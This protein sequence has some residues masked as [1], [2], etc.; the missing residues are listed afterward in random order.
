MKKGKVFTT[1]LSSMLVLSL[2]AGCGNSATNSQTPTP[3][4][5]QST[6]TET[7]TP[8]DE[9]PYADPIHFSG[10]GL[11]EL[12]EGV[13]Y[14]N[15]A[16]Y[17]TLSQKFNFTYEL[18]PMTWDNWGE[19]NRLWISSGD[20]PDL[21]FWDFNYTEYKNYAEQGLIRALPDGWEAKYPN[22]NAVV[23]A[24]GIKDKI[25]FDGKIYA[26]PKPV[27]MHFA[28]L[29]ESIS[30]TSVYYRADWVKELGLEP[31]GDTVTVDELASFINA[32]KTAD[33]DG[34]GSGKTIGITANYNNAVSMFVSQKNKGWNSFY[35]KDGK[36]VWGPAQPETLEGI[37]LLKKYY[38]MG[39]LDPDFYLNDAKENRNK[40]ASGISA[41]TYDDGTIDNLNNRIK[42]F[43]AANPDK[44]AAS[45]IGLT[46]LVGE[47]GKWHGLGGANFWCASVFSPT[48]SEEKMDRILS[49]Y[50]Y[51][52]SK[53]GQELVGLGIEGTDWERTADGYKLLRSANADGTIP[54]LKTV[55]PSAAF[56]YLLVILPD[57]FSFADPTADPAV[58]DQVVNMYNVKKDNGDIQPYDY[59]FQFYSS[60]AKSN[61][62]VAT[63]D[64]IVRIVM[65]PNAD[66]DAEWA[67]F[68]DAQKGM[69]N[70]L[71][72][73]LNSAFGK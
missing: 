48:M 17:Q 49:L 63:A 22:L 55:Y 67:K 71:L 30:H 26:L 57:D 10:T 42:E 5:S 41:I 35:K 70:P 20:M 73:E 32:A 28:P 9:N 46:T 68:I 53:E 27:F 62:S 1:L 61:Y 31:F 65:L 33:L 43:A 24:T 36:Y 45:A 38:D 44:D 14:S 58:V 6:G 25:T 8:T 18:Y 66:I 34:H 39:L 64:E 21:T 7:Q 60:D 11:A 3:S 52:A 54:L 59:D 23:E 19:K 29:S 15:D 50:D 56:W 4:P 2:A 40:F 13:D 12:S 51:L 72:D 47:D 69:V 37:K 16:I